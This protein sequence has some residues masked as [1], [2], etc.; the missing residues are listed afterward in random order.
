LSGERIL[1]VDDGA[2]MREFVIKYV[3][4]PNGYEYLEARDG[5]EGFEQIVNGQPD[6]IL[7]DLQMPRLDGVG[8]LKK[9]Q[10][11][12]INLP[13]VLMTFYGSE[14]IAIEVFRL[15]VRDYV[16]KPFTEEEL[17]EAIGRALAVSRLR[18]ERE[19][20]TERLTV[21]SR[22]FQRRVRELQ[23]LYRVGKLVVEQPD[24]DT[25]MIRVLEAASYLCGADWAAL[26]LVGE[27][28]EHLIQRAVKLDQ[29]PVLA[30]EVVEN[31]LA[32]QAMRGGQALAGEPSVDSA[33][34]LRSAQL[35]APLLARN[36]PIGALCVTT[37]ADSVSEHQ[38]Q[39]L[40]AL[41]DYAAI[42][43]EMSR[44]AAALAEQ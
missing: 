4:A 34:G 12:Q 15:G 41:A 17:L 13:V 19:V 22:D 33:G 1:V 18:R 9:M 32:W 11:N 30:S 14:E 26:L 29:E 39:M 20:L 36:T 44:M 23:G 6:L 3:L 8:L 35:S 7:L 5:V 42:G 38:L 28:E 10:D 31:P 27:D 40:S 37:A 43:L 21:A 16:I 2:D 25:L 24:A